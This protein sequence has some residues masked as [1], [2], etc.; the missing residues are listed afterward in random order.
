MTNT[1]RPPPHRTRS[2][3]SARSALAANGRSGRYWPV[4]ADLAK[5][6]R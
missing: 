3:R 1:P 5:L 6:C 4:M 2:T